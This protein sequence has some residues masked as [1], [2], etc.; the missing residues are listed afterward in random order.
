MNLLTESLFIK[1]FKRFTSYF[2]YT[3][4]FNFYCKSGSVSILQSVTVP[5]LKFKN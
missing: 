1:V 2:P 4:K 3:A 5:K